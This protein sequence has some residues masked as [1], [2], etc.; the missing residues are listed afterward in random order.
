VAAIIVMSLKTI[1]A[2]VTMVS[3]IYAI[4]IAGNVI[5]LGIL[6]WVY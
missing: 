3:I 6:G 4:A 1:R 5:G 2:K